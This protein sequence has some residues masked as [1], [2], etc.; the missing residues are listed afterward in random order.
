MTEK[1]VLNGRLRHA[2]AESARARSEVVVTK[3]RNTIQIIEAEIEANH[4]VY[5]YPGTKLG[6]REFCRRA[7]IHFQ[8]LQ[9]PAHKHTTRLEVEAFFAKHRQN[10]TK[11][12]IKTAVTERVDFWKGE[13]EKVASQIHIYEL[14]LNEQDVNIRKMQAAHEKALKDLR[15]EISHLNADNESLRAQLSLAMSGKKV[16]PIR[17]KGK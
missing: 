13:H 14:E 16:T 7:G 12:A 3:I 10:K 2:A 4:G 15:D 1:K 11:Q 5:P 9:T 6:Q 8:T 17:P